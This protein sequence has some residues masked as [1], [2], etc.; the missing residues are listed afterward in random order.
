MTQ[1]TYELTELQFAD[2]M[3]MRPCELEDLLQEIEHAGDDLRD[4]ENSCF[5]WEL[6]DAEDMAEALQD[7][8]DNILAVL[9]EV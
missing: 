1:R 5:A 4:Y 2:L 8:R 7:V 3:Y 9:G 6:N